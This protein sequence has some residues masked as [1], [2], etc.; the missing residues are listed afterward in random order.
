M[1][2]SLS[3]AI[4]GYLDDLGL[5]A[6]SERSLSFVEQ[7][8]SQHV[9]R[10]S[11]N[12]LA[13]LLKQNLPLELEAVSEKLVERKLGGY[14][15]EH[16]KL[17]FETLKAL[18]YDVKLVMARVLNNRPIEAPRTHRVTL[19]TLDKT[20][21]LIDVGFGAN[22]PILPLTLTMNNLQTAGQD[23]YRFTE[24]TNEFGLAEFDLEVRTPDGFFTLYRFDLAD[25]TDADCK[26][27]HFYSHQHPDAVFVN[28][29]VATRK[30]HDTTYALLN[31]RFKITTQGEVDV[32]FV[33][34]AESLQTILAE[35][36]SIHLDKVIT[37]HLFARFITP[38][39]LER[40][41]ETAQGNKGA[42]S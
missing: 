40:E 18:G 7:L 36:F 34:T 39:L 12:S 8:Q 24:Q 35:V 25:Y 2:K 22:C 23:V 16:N 37:E 32:Q 5:L 11:F 29:L 10:Y 14:C 27:G 6:P 41:R 1:S 17:I 42:L 15:F 28:N 3:P 38:A 20:H 9:A 19:L 21:Y 31:E 30:T 26:I 13:V 4:Q 33:Q